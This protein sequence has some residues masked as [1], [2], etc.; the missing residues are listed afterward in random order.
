M[1]LASSRQATGGGEGKPIALVAEVMGADG[2]G[3]ANGRRRAQPVR[4]SDVDTLRTHVYFIYLLYFSEI[5][6]KYAINNG[7]K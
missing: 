6:T 4:C 7:L 3:L 1:T 5:K 2:S